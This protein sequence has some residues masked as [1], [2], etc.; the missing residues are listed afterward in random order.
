MEPWKP[1]LK[2]LKLRLE[3]YTHP[4]NPPQQSDTRCLISHMS[5]TDRKVT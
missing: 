3:K 5:L 2:L 4:Q 1:P